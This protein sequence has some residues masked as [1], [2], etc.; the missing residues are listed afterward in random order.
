M[1]GDKAHSE[2]PYLHDAE[3][4]NMDAPNEVLSIIMELFQPT[5]VVDFGCGTGTWLA[6]FQNAGIE[7]LKGHEGAWLDQEASTTCSQFVSLKLRKCICI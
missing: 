4:H 5:S 7:D 6:A 1:N 3:V 2:I